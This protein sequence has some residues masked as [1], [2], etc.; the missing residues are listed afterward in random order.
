[1]SNGEVIFNKLD[2]SNEAYILRKGTIIYE[3]MPGYEFAVTGVEKIFGASEILLNNKYGIAEPRHF[4]V[5]EGEKCDYAPI[6]KENL[7]KWIKEYN[8]GWNAGNH[9]AEIITK[10]HKIVIDFEK[11]M[12]DYEKESKDLLALYATIVNILKEKAHEKNMDWFDE[13]VSK[14]ESE[15]IYTKGIQFIETPSRIEIN[16]TQS[17]DK[18]KKTYKKGDFICKKGDDADALYI[19]SNGNIKVTLDD[20][21]ALD[22]ISEK[23]TVIGEMAI[24]L[25]DKR[26]A[27]LVAV[28]DVTIITIDRSDIKELFKSEP[29]IFINTITN[30]AM[31]EAYN[32]NYIQKLYEMVTKNP[33][34]RKQKI[35]TQ[36]EE[37]KKE[38]KE[39]KN[40]IDKLCED[41]NHYTW[42]F[43][44]KKSTDKKF[45]TVG[46]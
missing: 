22:L 39:L 38:L 45:N 43:D 46:I 26:T 32:C 30:L 23:G 12:E 2:D 4:T 15:P 6:P 21:T 40:R 14:L 19:L 24:L 36:N 9:L 7:N 42:L 10:L 31:R 13:F 17:L 11:Q 34:E 33:D 35:E 8:I 28:D 3:V 29:S 5:K 16:N 44:L 27:N 18:F 20:G 37:Y 25:N 41:Y 1:M